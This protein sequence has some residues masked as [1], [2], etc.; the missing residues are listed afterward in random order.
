[1]KKS[2]LIVFFAG[3][4]TI[5]TI[6]FSP[7]AMA[8]GIG[9]E[10]TVGLSL[11]YTGPLGGTASSIS[12]G[13]L[14]H[15]MWIN[16]QGGI[17][18]KEPGTGK[19]ERVKMKIKWEDNA[20]NSSKSLSIYKRFKAAGAMV[21]CSLG[22]P[23]GEA[24]SA[25]LSRDRVPG[26]GFYAG[27]SPAGFRHEPNYY[28]TSSSTLTEE[29]CT[30]VKWFMSDWKGTRPPKIGGMSMDAP[31]WRPMGEPGGV[32]AYVEKAGGKWVGIEWVP[33]IVTDTSI[34]IKRLVS[35]GVDAIVVFGGISHGIVIAKDMFRLGIDFKKVKVLYGTPTWD[36][37]LIDL[38][39]KEAEGI[40]VSS[41]YTFSW[42][43]LPGVRLAKKVREWRGRSGEMGSYLRGFVFGYGLK[44][45]LKS[46]L[47]KV[48]YEKITP[49]DIRDALFS[50]KDLDAGGL[51][52]KINVREPDYPQYCSHTRFA[53][54]EGGRFKIIS[55]WVEMEKV[56]YG[57]R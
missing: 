5:F 50:L 39:P 30:S 45:A 7:L 27:A 13:F 17:E 46:A 21:V 20:Y 35:K 33:M 37:R 11:T 18:Y 8:Q 34:Q 43:D 23:T 3:L 56:E 36:E 32:K 9:K 29:F 42:E 48:G 2:A 53:I 47:E 15:L 12:D 40:I 4:F 16:N 26:V 14:D 1:M 57:R 19:S 28:S 54:V 25:S 52:Y 24:I 49:T 44:A 41:P 55:D 51:M 38:V 31:S 6:N 22:S 10:I